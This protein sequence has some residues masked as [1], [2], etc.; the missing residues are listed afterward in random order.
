MTTKFIHLRV[1]HADTALQFGGLTVAY[2]VIPNGDGSPEK[3]VYAIS[4]CHSRDR[5]DKAKG[6]IVSEGR[7]HCHRGDKVRV[8]TYRPNVRVTDQVFSDLR[9]LSESDGLNALLPNK[10]AA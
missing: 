8:L 1:A 3:I 4:A 6:R 5:Y 10:K 7:L 9:D 2:D